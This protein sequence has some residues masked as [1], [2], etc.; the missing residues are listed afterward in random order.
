MRSRRS[1][2]PLKSVLLA[3]VAI[4]LMSVSIILVFEHSMKK[5][6]LR[7]QYDVMETLAKEL[8]STNIEISNDVKSDVRFLSSL[9]PIQGIIRAQYN[10][11]IDPL[12]ED[13]EQVWRRRLEQIFESFIVS[14]PNYAQVRYIGLADYGR[15][16]VRVDRTANGAKIIREPHLQEKGHRDYVTRVSKLQPGEI[17][18]SN[19]NL[20]REH[21]VIVEP[22][23]PTRRYA[24]PVFDSAGQVFGLIVI[25]LN[26]AK[27]IERINEVSRELFSDDNARA[28]IVDSK[29]YY[30]FHPNRD[31]TFGFEFAKDNFWFDDFSGLDKNI[32][33]SEKT[34]ISGKTLSAING[35][36]F[37]TAYFPMDIDEVADAKLG[38]VFAIPPFSSKDMLAS[39]R[40]LVVVFSTAVVAI[41]LFLF[42]SIFFRQ[43]RSLR[44]LA[45]SAKEI[46]EGNYQVDLPKFTDDAMASLAQGFRYLQD[47]VRERESR[48]KRSE[49]RARHILNS[50][51][52]GILLID[53]QG[54]IRSSNRTA[55]DLLQYEDSELV[56]L[57]GLDNVFGSDFEK[58]F[59]KIRELIEVDITPTK[60]YEF[61][62]MPRQGEP[63]NA[64]VS[65]SSVD[66]TGK[67]YIL[68]TFSNITDRKKAQEKL[69]EYRAKLEETIRLREKELKA[70]GEFMANMSHE[71]RTPMT[72]ILGLLDIVRGT[73]LSEKQRQYIYQIYESS[74]ALL[75]IINDIL[76][77]SKIEAG[78]IELVKAPFSLLRVSE[79][80]TDLF[81]P[82]AE[83]KG[84]ETFLNYDP[85]ITYQ[86]I[87]DGPRLT[88]VLSNLV[89]NAVKF[90][91]EGEIVLGVECLEVRGGHIRVRFYV[92][93]T[94][95]GMDAS[96]L[97]RLFEAFEQADSATTRVYGGSG[98]GLTI[99]SNLIELMGG[100]LEA[101]TKVGSGSR[102]WFDLEFEMS[103]QPEISVG[104]V[105]DLNRRVLVVDDQEISCEVLSEMLCHWGCDVVTASN[106]QEGL[107]LFERA[108]EEGYPFSIVITDT[109][110]PGMDGYQLAQRIIEFSKSLGLVIDTPVLMIGEIQRSELFKNSRTVTGVEL[111]NKPVTMS[112]LL[113][114]LSNLGVISMVKDER[115]SRDWKDLEQILLTKLSQNPGKAK[116]LLV[117]D[118]ETNQMVVK[119]LLSKFPLEIECAENGAVG[120]E[121]VREN[122]YDLVLM[123][124][125]MP[126]MDGFQAT[127]I[128]R[129][130]KS[131]EELP[132]LALSAASFME[133]IN[134]AI[135]AGMNEH[136]M[137]PIDIR[138]LYQA[139]I[140]WLFSPAGQGKDEEVGASAVAASVSEPEVT[141][142]QDKNAVLERIRND[143]NFDLSVTLISVL[144]EQG[145]L[146]LVDTFKSEFSG[147]VSQWR[148]SPDWDGDKKRLVAHSIK[149]ASQS[150]G[151]VALKE[152]AETVELALKEGREVNYSALISMLE[153]TLDIL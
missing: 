144:G 89:G 133:D 103:T 48:L 82:S 24:T 111:L 102:F 96:T 150:I 99:S 19:I 72:A 33:T 79:N 134:K 80:V 142:S 61:M 131:K 22:Y 97:D 132:I 147:T 37:Y 98:L 13:S 52:M 149:G 112:K 125:Q 11:G 121:K 101:E 43:S 83:L 130:L 6:Y 109:H 114:T 14:R 105:G 137:K 153:E 84:V 42:F 120:V 152:L 67:R 76:D 30:L 59:Y 41:F 34:L 138:Q 141:V 47:S 9:P 2:L 66:Y 93:D 46:A 81:S 117:E 104:L 113:N 127:E 62:A 15:E 126:K 58:V 129:G 140:K 20:N 88:Q 135:L 1:S 92:T 145:F 70:K 139:L 36:E 107:V 32:Q 8:G 51:P 148:E 136:L 110:V 10:N 53:S 106:G 146:R 35:D 38:V 123:D 63:F 100:K 118:N 86:V 16:L 73:D 12:D 119:E 25:N 17:Y 27:R 75:T 5:R 50:I 94:G 78:K 74:R 55:C 54:M 69:L 115:D 87:G 7:N 44:R 91:S 85:E 64:E 39:T 122:H 18:V 65:F 31:K 95:I 108:A 71:I 26:V 45:G 40:Y 60:L 4:V 128:I 56:E 23:E 3:L 124:L 21:G 57:R 151:A 68:T 77:L 90:T 116:I 143:S 49:Q 28:L 29:G